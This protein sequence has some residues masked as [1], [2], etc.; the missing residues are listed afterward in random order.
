MMWRISADTGGTF[1]D[2]YAVTP[3]GVIP[4]DEMKPALKLGQVARVPPL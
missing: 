3:D 4:K 2:C 1:T